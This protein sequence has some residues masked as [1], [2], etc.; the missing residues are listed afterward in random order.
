MAKSQPILR[1]VGLMS[2]TSMDGIDAALI[3]SDGET[4]VRVLGFHS[5]PYDDAFRVQLRAGMAAAQTILSP[6]PEAE[7]FASLT[8]SLTLRHAEAVQQ[9]L[10]Q[11][12]VSPESVDLI[13]FHGQTL[14][15]RPDQRW[16]WQI[17]DGALLAQ[18]TG[19]SVV[20][21]FRSADVAAGG[22]GAPLL[23]LYHAARARA[24]GLVL[25]VAVLNLG[26]VGNVTWIGPGG[27]DLLAFDTGPGNAL[28][29]DWLLQATGRPL[30]QDGALAAAGAIRMDVLTAMLDHPYFDEPAPK[31]LDRGDFTTQ[32]ALGLPAADGAATLTAFTAETVRLA[33]GHLP[34]PPRH[35]LVTGGGRRNPTLMRMLADRLGAPVQPVDTLGWDGDALEAEGFAY[36]AIRSHHGLPL[37]VPG[38]TGVPH[39]LTG[40]VLHPRPAPRAA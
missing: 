20:H 35:W 33:L 32:P 3:E 14:V 8:R 17:G 19:I 5:L 28:I 37:S 25:P 1:A 31:S 18:M 22:Q 10:E 38:T 11:L 21:D 9:L 40:G 4:Q 13:G 7:P 16:T 6:Q 12:S 39:P 27:A 2:G 24:A 15:H 36:L 34:Q 26:G 30:D 23:P 29:D